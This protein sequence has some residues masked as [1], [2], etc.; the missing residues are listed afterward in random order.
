MHITFT[1]SGGFAGLTLHT[2][3][4]T[5]A[6]P[7]DEARP[8]EQAIREA[9]FFALPA[10]TPPGRGAD[11]FQYAISVE[12]GGRQHSV[13]L[14]ESDVPPTLKPLI[15]QLLDRARGK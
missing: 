1:R 10:S 6:L 9:D 11:Q 3:V 7:P 15:G 12:A 8:L 14:G 4:D 5:S 2:S 13:A